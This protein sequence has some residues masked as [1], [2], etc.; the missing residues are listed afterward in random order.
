V[1]IYV[2]IFWRKKLKVNSKKLYVHICKV[3]FLPFGD[4]IDLVLL[5]KENEGK[6]SVPRVMRPSL[7]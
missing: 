2:S 6:I 5:E 1:K 7:F 4:L 3:S